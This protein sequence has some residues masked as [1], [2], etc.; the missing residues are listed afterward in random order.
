M[1]SAPAQPARLGEQ[2]QQK[3]ALGFWRNR[4]NLALGIPLAN[5]PLDGLIRISSE[6]MRNILNHSK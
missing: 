4:N 1:K 3:P 6:A 5:Q 2:R